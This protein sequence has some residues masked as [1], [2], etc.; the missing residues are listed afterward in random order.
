MGK[1]LK[2]R[3]CANFVLSGWW[4]PEKVCSVSGF[5]TDKNE[6]ACISFKPKDDAENKKS[7]V[8]NVR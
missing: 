7:D 3:D 4:D 1:E 6:S 8:R 2:C 5:P